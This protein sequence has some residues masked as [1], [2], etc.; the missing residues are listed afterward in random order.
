MNMWKYVVIAG[1]VLLGR[2]NAELVFD[3]DSDAKTFSLTG[4]TFGN[5]ENN[6]FGYA[7]TWSD[8]PVVQDYNWL[9]FSVDASAAFTDSFDGFCTVDFYTTGFYDLYIDDVTVDHPVLTGSG[10]D[11]SYASLTLDQ[12]NKF[13]GMIGKKLNL[14]AGSGYEAITVV[15]E[16]A[17]A[18][19][20]AI[21]GLGMLLVRRIYRSYWV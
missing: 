21:S 3:I 11:V 15:P 12:Q 17:S 14:L 19:L 6:S 5:F 10:L 20:V 18:M 4:S 2:A 9:D 1:F 8:A 16:P 13:E 7:V